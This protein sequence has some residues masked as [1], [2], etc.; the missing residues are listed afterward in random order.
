[1]KLSK[2]YINLLP[3]AEAKA[4]VFFSP[5][6]AL[7]VLFVLLWLGLFGWQMEQ[8]RGLRKQLA[9]IDAN[10]QSLRQQVAALQKELGVAAPADM[11]PEKAAL[12]N[13]LISERVPWSA[14]FKQFSQIVPKGLWFD[15]LEG[16][17]AGK[18]EIRVRGG[19]FNYLSVAEFMLAMDKTGYFENPQLS[20]AQKAVVQGH[21]VIGFE[22]VCGIRKMQRVQ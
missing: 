9:L 13:T 3:H 17:A 20:Y 14:V 21:E 22:I 4:A 11:S 1:M 6:F 8:A 5:A 15:S 7:A 2:D 16:S 18:A 12:I 10:R 19:A